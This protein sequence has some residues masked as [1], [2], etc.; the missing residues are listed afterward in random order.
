MERKHLLLE[1][2]VL[3]GNLAMVGALQDACEATYGTT[4]R[5][6]IEYYKRL[7][8]EED[9]SAGWTCGLCYC[10]FDATTGMYL[11]HAT[12]GL[13][14]LHWTFLARDRIIPP[15]PCGMCGL[16]KVRNDSLWCFDCAPAMNRCEFEVNGGGGIKCRNHANYI[17]DNKFMNV[18]RK[19]CSV[20][21]DFI[22]KTLESNA[23]VSLRQLI[24]VKSLY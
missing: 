20:C 10:I 17:V 24:I 3:R 11:S 8:P 19:S 4:H 23:G 22:K 1:E 16:P 9:L 2:V 7:F 12:T 15:F 5:W 6:A 18:T 13:T 21:V 14:E